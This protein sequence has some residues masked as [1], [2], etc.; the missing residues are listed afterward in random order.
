M[1]LMFYME[2]K[3]QFN[4]YYSLDFL[5]ALSYVRHIACKA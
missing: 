4:L 1:L 2:G 5:K 3:P